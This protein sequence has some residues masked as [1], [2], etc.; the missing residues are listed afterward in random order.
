MVTPPICIGDYSK[1]IA[2]IVETYTISSH[3][4]KAAM[5]EDTA[6]RTAHPW[7]DDT[8]DSAPTAALPYQWNKTVTTYSDGTS[9][10]TYHISAARGS[11]GTD[12]DVW[13]IGEDGYWYK[14]GV[15]QDTK[16][17]GTSG[18]DG[19]MVTA[20][21]ANVIITQA[22]GNE[23][24]QFST[25]KVGFTAKK[26]SVSATVSSLAIPTG[27]QVLSNE[28]NAA[29]GT[30]DDAKKVIVSSPKTYTP[31]G[32]T[33][34]YYTE[35]TFVVD[36]IATDPDTGS[37]VTFNVTVPCYA[38]L[39]GTWKDTVEADVKH[40]VATSKFYFE[41]ENGNVVAH[42]TIGDFIK[43][44]TEN[45]S[46]LTKKVNEGKNL[47]TLTS[48]WEGFDGAAVNYDE[49]NFGV[50]D[51]N[52][53]LYSPFIR[54]AEGQSVCFSAYMSSDAAQ[55]DNWYIG[56]GST[57]PVHLSD[58]YDN[59]HISIALI[60]KPG[61]S[62]TV[63]GTTYDRYYY[64][65]NASS[66]FADQYITFNLANLYKLFCPQLEIGD[67]PTAF[68][69]SSVETSSQIH[70]SAD[71]VDLSITNNPGQTGINIA[72]QTIRLQA[73]KVTFSDSQGG[74]TDKI[75]IDPATGTLH[76]V[77]GKFSGNIYTPYKRLTSSNIGEYET[78]DF[79]GDT[80]INLAKT[81]LNLQVEVSREEPTQVVHISLPKITA[82]M[83]G[84]EVNIFNA[85]GDVIEIDGSGRA[86]STDSG[87]YFTAL[88]KS[89]VG[90]GTN[91]TLNL[92][93]GYE[94]KL[95]AIHNPYMTQ[96]ENF[97]Y[98]WLCCYANIN[99]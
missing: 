64:V 30:G 90:L 50:W 77:D 60:Q 39:I 86:G 41:D 85:S 43:S 48:G 31:Q 24:T 22:L 7:V 54:L 79:Y 87:G 53:D 20:A 78:E 3:V 42:E 28:F 38:N 26:G 45:T 37:S 81:G 94:A 27:Q 8:Q 11:N 58:L 9:D 49:K 74:N 84:C 95:K 71:E 56:Y 16:A 44:S 59:A 14:N 2:S 52:S 23:T 34:Q 73:D 91:T 75:S 35:G 1:G 10:T 96:H 88:V 15:R 19:W 83:L 70:Q 47:L 67:A 4:T 25:V 32:G 40:E 89:S 18:K 33:A 66:V 51:T 36:V 17:E 82:D 62:I 97:Q 98:S 61:D 6:E 93:A 57:P 99:P 65:L 46:V 68:T 92:N 63:D 55:S 72:N 69:A 21:P 12:A 13:T 5:L 80:V 29:I 76:A